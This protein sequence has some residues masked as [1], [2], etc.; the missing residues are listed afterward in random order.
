MLLLLYLGPEILMPL[1]SALAAVGGGVMMFWHK[2]QKGTR[3]IFGRKG[4]E[5]ITGSPESDTTSA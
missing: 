2:I 3:A 1:V 4:Q 5:P